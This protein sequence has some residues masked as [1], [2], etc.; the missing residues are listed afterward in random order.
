LIHDF[1]PGERQVLDHSCGLPHV[2]DFSWAML[3]AE[4]DTGEPCFGDSI[5]DAVPSGQVILDLFPLHHATRDDAN[6]DER[7]TN[8][9][10][11]LSFHHVF[12]LGGNKNPATSNP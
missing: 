10:P 6:V 12:P 2:G 11:A 3:W 1:D 5:P 7:K 9:P 8:E 4:C